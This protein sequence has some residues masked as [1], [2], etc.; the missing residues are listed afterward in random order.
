[1]QLYGNSPYAN[2]QYLVNQ[3]LQKYSDGISQA[4]RNVEINSNGESEY[5]AT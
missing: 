4:D 3:Q 5:L 1:M 2:N